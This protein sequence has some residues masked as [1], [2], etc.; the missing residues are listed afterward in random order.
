MPN[1]PFGW[2]CRNTTTFFGIFWVVPVVDFL[3]IYLFIL[4][5]RSI[6]KTKTQEDIF[7]CPAGA[8]NNF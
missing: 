5:M 3:F 6:S 7:S 2:N 1:S 8:E 4:N